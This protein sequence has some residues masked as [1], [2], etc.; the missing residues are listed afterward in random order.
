MNN[1][2]IDDNAIEVTLATS[3][4]RELPS[5]NNDYIDLGK[6]ITIPVSKQNSSNDLHKLDFHTKNLNLS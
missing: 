4:N 6:K 2:F 1:N 5:V 3:Y